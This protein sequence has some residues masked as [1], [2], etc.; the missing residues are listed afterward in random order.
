M[1]AISNIDNLMNLSKGTPPLDRA[2]NLT[3]IQ[4]KQWGVRQ[5]HTGHTWI[6]QELITSLYQSRSGGRLD[7]C[8]HTNRGINH[9]GTYRQAVEVDQ[10]D[11]AV[12][13]EELAEI[14][15]TPTPKGWL[16]PKK[17][18]DLYLID[19]L[20]TITGVWY[21]YPEPKHESYSSMICYNLCIKWKHS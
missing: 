3:L 16:E 8:S 4:F 7:R 20:I 14:Y 13:A 21:L 11:A 17:V 12:L 2:D 19:W 6:R 10:I 15:S 5:N 18:I 9:D 1:E